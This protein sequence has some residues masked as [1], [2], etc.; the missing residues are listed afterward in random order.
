MANRAAHDVLAE[1]RPGEMIA[2]HC[3]HFKSRY[4]RIL[5]EEIAGARVSECRTRGIEIAH[6]DIPVDPKR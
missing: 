1:A 2:V 6:F 3:I 4:E 5:K